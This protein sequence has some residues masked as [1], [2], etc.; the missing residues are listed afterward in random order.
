MVIK[1]ILIAVGLAALVLGVYFFQKAWRGIIA[2]EDAH[3]PRP[4]GERRIT[5][6]SFNLSLAIVGTI[7]GIVLLMIGLLL[8]GD[9]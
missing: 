1:W 2:V 8:K 3:L 6:L 5:E 9:M 7:V 4:H